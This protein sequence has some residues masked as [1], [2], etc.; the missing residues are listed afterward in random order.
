MLDG[1]ADD[2]GFA[3]GA[4]DEEVKVAYGLAATAERA[5]GGDLVDAG[6]GADEGAD[7]FC[8]ALRL[9]DAEATGVLAVIF[10]ALQQFGDEFFS[11]AWE[12]G[13][14][15]CLGGYFEAVNVA[16]LTGGPDE[17]YGLG[18]HAGKAE[19]LEHGGLVLLEQFFA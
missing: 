17:S 7:I 4:S 3:G 13:E 10:D 5:C 6:E 18:T 15:A 19:K 1:C 12:L 8:I 14:M 9:I 2:V 11:H 16:D